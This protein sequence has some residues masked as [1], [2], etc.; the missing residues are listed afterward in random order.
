MVESDTIATPADRGVAVGVGVLVFVGVWVGVKVDVFVGVFE[1]VGEELGLGAGVGVGG[2][3][4][5]PS[6]S[7]KCT[8][9]LPSPLQEMRK[10]D[11]PPPR[12][13]FK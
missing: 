10:S 9:S 7:T 8:I 6:T 3:P 1:G 11:V 12:L 5:L 4:Y 2:S 13:L